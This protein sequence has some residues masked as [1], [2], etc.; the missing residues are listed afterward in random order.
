[1]NL[2]IHKKSL[3]LKKKSQEIVLPKGYKRVSYL[4]TV[5]GAYIDPN[6]TANDAYPSFKFRFN[7]S[8]DQLSSEK[9]YLLGRLYINLSVYNLSGGKLIYGVYGAFNAHHGFTTD[10]WHEVEF[11]NGRLV[12]DGVEKTIT[13]YYKGTGTLYLFRHADVEQDKEF[14][15][16]DVQISTGK[17]NPTIARNL[18]CCVREADGVAGMY[19]LCGSICPLTDSPF[20]I[21]AG[22]G[23]LLAD[24]ISTA[25]R[26]PSE[27]Q[28]VE[29][30]EGTGTQY[31]NINHTKSKVRGFDVKYMPTTTEPY[32]VFG[33][34]DNNTDYISRCELFRYTQTTIMIN[35]D[36]VY[37]YIGPQYF[38][39]NDWNN[40]SYIDEVVRVNDVVVSS[41][42]ENLKRPNTNNIILFGRNVAETITASPLRMARFKLYESSGIVRDMIPCYRK[43]DGVGGMYDLCG[44]ICPLTGTPFYMNAGTGDFERGDDV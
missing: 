17:D 43:S 15:L 3:L 31:I 10:T 24:G 6:L 8:A 40:V 2:A 13:E 25:G 37:S 11:G 34:N 41:S 32:Y 12:L 27:Y 16:S 5:G 42:M 7:V 44:S 35:W 26:L 19:D 28:E 4:E 18:I 33:S 9:L 39:L 14:K 38:A 29:Y 21:N 20:Y 22:E 36:S 30:I 23:E 1:M